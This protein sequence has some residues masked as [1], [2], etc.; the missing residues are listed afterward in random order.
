MLT[1][2][3]KTSSDKKLIKMKIPKAKHWINVVSPSEDEIKYL[4]KHFKIPKDVIQDIMDENELPRIEKEKDT[5]IVIIRIPHR[6]DT[7]YG[8][9]FT[10][11]P[12]GVVITDGVI[13]TICN[14]ENEVIDS[15]V[16]GKV[17][18]FYT[19]K[20]VRFLLQ[21][22][23]RTNY[24]FTVYLRYIEHM[25][26]QTKEHL[27]KSAGNREIM[28]LLEMQKSLQYFSIAT[29]ANNSVMQRII[30]GRLLPMYKNDQDILEDIIIDNRQTIQMISLYSQLLTN[31][32]NGYSSIVSNNLNNIM[33]F[34]TSITIL[35]AIPTIISSYYGMNVNLPFQTSQ[36]A[37]WLIMVI[38][39]IATGGVALLLAYRK[40]L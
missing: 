32:M 10:T 3:R 34:L 23:N 28:M 27:P 38:S 40:L 20:R 14:K 16:K 13:I 35:L 1:I 25:I 4:E 12:L 18:Q 19:S 21:L 36:S 9:A 37:F 6:I 11:Y 8:P 24:Y 30:S 7:K 39:V 29:V 2:Y 17:K 15:F 22:L 33:K 5:V 26:E 31:F